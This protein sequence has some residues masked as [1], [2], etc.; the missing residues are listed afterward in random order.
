MDG[1][2]A[3]NGIGV[4]YWPGH[5]VLTN[6]FWIGSDFSGTQQ[7][8]GQFVDVESWADQF[9]S[10]NF[11]HYYNNILPE[12][13]GSFI[14]FGGFGGFGPDFMP[15]SG[16]FGGGG[17]GSWWTNSI[18]GTNL[19]LYIAGVETNTVGLFLMNT[20]PD[21]LYEIQSTTNLLPTA[22]VSAGFVYGSELTNFAEMD[23][24]M[25]DCVPD[26][27]YRIRSWIDSEDVGIPDWWQLKYFGYVGIDPDADPDGDGMD[28][29]EEFENGTDPTVFDFPSGPEEFTAILNPDTSVT[30]TWETPVG[31]VTGYTLQRYDSVSGQEV[32]FTLGVTNEFVDTSFT[33]YPVWDYPIQYHIQASYADGASGWSYAYVN[34]PDGAI[35]AKVLLGSGGST[36]LAVSGFPASASGLQIT[37]ADYSSRP[38]ISASN[39]FYVPA[40]SL[41]NGAYIVPTNM[42]GL[43]YDG[44]DWYVQTVWS[45]ATT[46]VRSLASGAGY[47]TAQSYYGGAFTPGRFNDASTQMVQNVTFFLRAAGLTSPFQYSFNAG[48]GNTAVVQPT[49]YAYV[50]YWNVN[51]NTGDGLGSGSY[52]D[53][54]M[55]FQQNYRLRNFVFSTTNVGS[56]GYLNTGVNSDY[57]MQSTVTFTFP[58]TNTVGLSGLLSAGQTT[59][60]V[61]SSESALGIT[62]TSSQFSLANNIYNYFGLKLLSVM[63]AHVHGGTLYF[64]TLNAGGT[65]ART[66]DTYYF[67]GQYDQ[68]QLQTV[69][70]Y[71]GKTVLNSVPD[72][73]FGADFLTADP[74]PGDNAFSPTNAQPLLIGSVGNQM[75]IAAFAKQTITNGD[76]SKP[77]YVSQYFDKAYKIDA[78]GNVT[79]NQT[80]VLSP[81]GIFLPTESGPTALVTLPASDGQRGTG[82]VYVVSLQL[83]ANHDGNMD[84]SYY[85]QDYT[86]GNG[87][88]GSGSQTMP[89]W[90]NDGHDEPGDGTTLDYDE[91]VLPSAYGYTGGQVQ[92]NYAYGQIRCQRNLENFARL[93]VSGLPNL[94]T[95]YTAVLDLHDFSSGQINLYQACDTNGGTGYLTDTNVAATQINSTYGNSLGQLSS[96]FDEWWNGDGYALPVDGSGHPLQTHFLFEGAGYPGYS[97][98]TGLQRILLSIFKDGNLVAQSAACVNFSHAK[99]LYERAVVTNVIQTWPE[100][101]QQT[102]VSGFEVLSSPAPAFNETNQLAVFVHGWRMTPWDTEDFSDTM[103]KRLYWQGYQGRFASLRWPTRSAETDTNLLLGLIPEANFTYNRSEHIAFESGTG[104]AAYLNNLRSRYTNYTISVAAH[105]MGNIVMMEALKEL[106]ASNEAP[107]DNY[108]LMQAA[109]PACCYDTTVTNIPLFTALES[110]IPTPNVYSNY[111]AGITN[112]L[113]GNGKL[114]NFYN[115]DDFALFVWQ[116]NE[117]FYLSSSDGPVTMKPN[118]FFGYSYDASNSVAQVTTND[119]QLGLGITN[120]Q[121]R[122]VT[123]PLELMPFV[124][125]PRSL[126]VGAQ[127]G[128]GQIITGGELDLTTLGFG[129]QEYDHSG[130]FKRNVQTRQVQGFYTNLV[131][132]MFPH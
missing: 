48:Y 23:I 38:S 40:S 21:V 6:G 100:M 96:L 64:D 128:V 12:L 17:G 125:R 99:D 54:G 44:S 57:S 63:V 69:G 27:F 72:Y 93:W 113:R 114:V 36:V 82:V 110:A 124:A 78:S 103:F 43:G 75:R 47:L 68:P 71:F 32:T 20:M 62:H 131:S 104:A 14:G 30:L 31:A 83:D 81:Y 129:D 85:D 8:R 11:Y 91:Q 15:P 95:N 122:A 42:T 108:V 37:R 58:S 89:F 67:Y 123:N 94:P 88:V 59:Y 74:I 130:Q 118:T 86:T 22:W 10:N 90:V 16:G 61:P 79:T 26:C 119:W 55:P 92:P 2:L 106:A 116:A 18:Y 3:T 9:S 33:N 76:T 45:N 111:A 1:Q 24:P 46:T 109:V 25:D 35:A 97:D 65:L 29:F 120:V 50:S 60:V 51:E 98:G 87:Y 41:A 101:V 102:N 84:S 52:L 7:A 13:P 77:V 127:G 112:A 66:N 70:Y 80:G 39:S 53:W 132:K 126:A 49:N 4:T 5:D 34:P 56:S 28:N 117:G 121:T 107:I 19:W 105:S 115:P 73:P